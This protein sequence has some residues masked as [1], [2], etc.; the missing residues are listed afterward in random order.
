MQARTIS[1]FT[2]PEL[3]DLID[4]AFVM[5]GEMEESNVAG[6]FYMDG[7]IPAGTGNSR[8]YDEF[9]IDTF[10]RNKP[11]GENAS[12]IN[13]AVGYSKTM[14]MKRIASEI[15]ITWEMRNNGKDQE[16]LNKIKAITHLVPNRKELDKTHQLFTFCTS[17]SYVDMDGTTVDVTG[18]DGQPAAYASHPLKYSSTTWRN[19]LSGDPVFAVG[20]LEAAEQLAATNIFNNFG[21]TRNLD[22]NV[23]FCGKDPNTNRN[24]RRILESTSDIDYANAGIKNTYSAYR[25]VMLPYLATTADGSYDST[26]RRW[27]GIA[28]AGQIQAHSGDWEPSRLISPSAGNNLEDAHNDNWTWGVRG[29]YGKCLVTAKG[30]IYSCPT[31]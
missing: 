5:V 20:A 16:I 25:K 29:A 6:Q 24:I 28:A 15:D 4:K 12:K 13:T 26:K 10:A 17:S 1:Q 14:Y 9:D 27:W 21:Q 8:R 22:F 3:V 23:I 7:G 19:R 30:L 11:E 2:L 31:N 18:G